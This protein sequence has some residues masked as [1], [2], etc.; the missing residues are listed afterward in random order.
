[1]TD[2]RAAHSRLAPARLLGAVRPSRDH[3][4]HDIGEL[5]QVEW[6]AEDRADEVESTETS[7]HRGVDE[8]RNHNGRWRPIGRQGLE[9]F[10]P[11]A[12]WH[13]EIADQD[14]NLRIQCALAGRFAIVDA[15]GTQPTP[16]QNVDQK[17]AH[18]PVIVGNQD[19]WCTQAGI[20]TTKPNGSNPSAMK[21]CFVTG[22]WPKGSDAQ[23][24]SGINQETSSNGTCTLTLP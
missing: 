10:E 5:K 22:C 9:D 3:F 8:A 11:G 2:E 23:P 15:D 1:M 7:L 13:V 24:P 19:E 17:R 6:L 21:N 14:G 18:G 12:L 16:S 4:G 20:L